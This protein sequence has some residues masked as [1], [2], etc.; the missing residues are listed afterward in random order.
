MLIRWLYTDRLDVLLGAPS[1]AV[2]GPLSK[3]PPEGQA[4]LMG[5]SLGCAACLLASY[6]FLSF[7]KAVNLLP[8]SLLHH[9]RVLSCTHL[10]LQD[11]NSSNSSSKT[12]GCLQ[13]HGSTPAQ[14]EGQGTPSSLH[15]RELEVR[16]Q[17]SLRST[18]A[19]GAVFVDALL[20]AA[21]TAAAGAA[22]IVGQM[23]MQWRLHEFL[24]GAAAELVQLLLQQ[25][26]QQ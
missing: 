24:L 23:W 5:L 9:I 21:R 22:A 6:L 1:S 26:L 25:K 14:P 11:S 8:A 18:T 7:L 10:L 4:I 12:Q 2:V 20:A 13:Y 15:S 19:A 16:L 17:E 3:G